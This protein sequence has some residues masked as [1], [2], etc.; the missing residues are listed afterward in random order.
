VGLRAGLDGRKISSPLQF[1]LFTSVC[2]A[3]LLLHSISHPFQTS[4]NQADW[5]Q[6]VLSV[7]LPPFYHSSS[8]P[9]L[10]LCKCLSLSPYAPVVATC[11]CCVPYAPMSSPFSSPL[12]IKMYL[13]HSLVQV[14]VVGGGGPSALPIISPNSCLL[15][16]TSSSPDS[17]STA[18]CVGSRYIPLATLFYGYALGSI[19]GSPGSTVSPDVVVVAKSGNW[20]P[21]ASQ[22]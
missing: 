6:F 21:G 8:L 20:A 19:R 16:P 14:Y 22:G 2:I 18:L 3:L 15:F 11:Y 17:S 5:P 10:L 4:K 1:F 13:S 9:T 12:V 7:T